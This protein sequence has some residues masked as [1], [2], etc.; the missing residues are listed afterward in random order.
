[1]ADDIPETEEEWKE[2]LTPEQYRILREGG[3]EPAGTGDYLEHDVDG[4]Y[5]CAACG[6][7]LFDSDTKFGSGDHGWPSFWAAIDE[8]NVEFHEDTSHGMTRIEVRCARCH[9]HLGHVFDDGPDPTGKRFCINS[10]ALD[11]E[12]DD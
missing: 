5:R 6:Q 8:A 2:E 11:F 7:D 4:T 12:P 10:A 9:S 3:T 1:M